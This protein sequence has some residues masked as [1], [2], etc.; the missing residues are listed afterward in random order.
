[1]YELIVDT[2]TSEQT[3]I[4]HS[5]EEAYA[6]VSALPVNSVWEI[7]AYPDCSAISEGMTW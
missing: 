1:M 6:I 7:R 3:Y 5:Y 2:E 4:C